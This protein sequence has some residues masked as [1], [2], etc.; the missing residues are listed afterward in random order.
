MF[1]AGSRCEREPTTV[2][3]IQLA[4]EFLLGLRLRDRVILTAHGRPLVKFAPLPAP[5]PVRS[6][7]HLLGSLR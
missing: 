6:V 5:T 2:T 3:L 7:R 4:E 1:S